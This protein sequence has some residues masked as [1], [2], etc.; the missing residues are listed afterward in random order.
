MG[1]KGERK[2]VK[3]THITIADD[4]ETKKKRK[5][6][7]MRLTTDGHDKEWQGKTKNFNT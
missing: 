2:T 7:E 6:K 4:D 3:T 5:K 1:E